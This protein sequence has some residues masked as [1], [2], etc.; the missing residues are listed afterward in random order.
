MTP[1]PAQIEAARHAC[2]AAS[3][4]LNQAATNAA[5]AQSAEDEYARAHERLALLEGRKPLRLKYRRGNS[6]RR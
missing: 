6:G 4:R 5:A 2:S 1:D 3:L